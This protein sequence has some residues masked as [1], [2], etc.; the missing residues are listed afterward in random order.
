ADHEGWYDA[1]DLEGLI[2]IQLSKCGKVVSHHL[3]GNLRK[4]LGCKV[5][6]P[7]RHVWAETESPGNH[8]TQIAAGAASLRDELRYPVQ[9][10]HQRLRD[11]VKGSARY[12]P[13]RGGVGHLASRL[14]KQGAPEDLISKQLGMAPGEPHDRHPAH[15][16]PDED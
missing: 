5:H 16:V 13:D 12:A 10:A 2:L 6:I 8:E 4:H 9:A 7:W 15:R 14:A 1:D 3:K 11:S